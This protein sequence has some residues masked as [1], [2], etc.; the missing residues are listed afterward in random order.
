MNA[1]VDCRDAPWFAQSERSP[2][3]ERP[4]PVW[5]RAQDCVTFA[6]RSLTVVSKRDSEVAACRWDLE[7]VRKTND[8]LLLQLDQTE[9]ESLP[10]IAELKAKS[11]GTM[12][13]WTDLDRLAAGDRGDG[14]VVS[15]RMESVRRHLALVFH[16]YLAGEVSSAPIRISINRAEIAPVDPF[17]ASKEVKPENST[18]NVLYR[19]PTDPPDGLT[20]P[21]ISKLRAD[22]VAIAGGAEGLRRQQGFYVYR[23]YRLIVWG[24]GFRLM[25][26][27]NSQS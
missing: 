26:R 24:T 21:H 10:C 14:A 9:I 7:F 23:N 11:H 27:R 16:R 13:L 19:R 4:R 17:L 20:L 18:R 1:G 5:A 2:R 12:V 15:A 3:E 6:M 25:R 8:W 22:E